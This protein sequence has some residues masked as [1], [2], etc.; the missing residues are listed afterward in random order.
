VAGS[1]YVSTPP[2][3]TLL[4]VFQGPSNLQTTAKNTRVTDELLASD[5]F[6]RLSGWANR[7]IAPS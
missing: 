5:C 3:I 6:Q 4:I 1:S 2:F 7:K